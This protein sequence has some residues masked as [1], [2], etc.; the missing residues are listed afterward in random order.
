MLAK[1]EWVE[2]TRK[3]RCFLN[4]RLN[5]HN[6]L[7]FL[8]FPE[9]KGLA[10]FHRC[11]DVRGGC[12][13]VVFFFRTL[14]GRCLLTIFSAL[15]ILTNLVLSDKHSFIFAEIHCALVKC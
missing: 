11:E 14:S 1:Y 9:G 4:H 12:S 3:Y 15:Q 6:Y 10:A 7:R 2:E 13:K 8:W 5:F